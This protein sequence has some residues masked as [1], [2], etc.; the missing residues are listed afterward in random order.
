LGQSLTEKD[1]QQRGAYGV[2]LVGKVKGAPVSIDFYIAEAR[3][4][5]R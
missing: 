5:G 4:V 1:T 2:S 3:L